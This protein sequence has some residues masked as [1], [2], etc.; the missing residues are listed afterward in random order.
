MTP[1]LP[2][3]LILLL[4]VPAA[5]AGHP[6]TDGAHDADSMSATHGIP[7]GKAFWRADAGHISG[8]IPIIR[9]GQPDGHH[10]GNDS[11]FSLQTKSIRVNWSGDGIRIK[12][13]GVPGHGLDVKTSVQ[14][15]DLSPMAFFTEREESPAADL[16]GK[17]LQF[18]RK[19]GPVPHVEY[20]APEEDADGFSVAWIFEHRPL[21]PGD[22]EVWISSGQQVRI[23]NTTDGHFIVSR[24]G[25]GF[26]AT[27]SLRISRAFLIDS[28]GM[29]VPMD[30]IIEGGSIRWR[31]PA[32]VLENAVYPLCLDPVIG[33]ERGV[34]LVSVTNNDNPQFSPRIVAVDD[35]FLAVWADQLPDGNHRIW[36]TRIDSLGNVL[37]PGGFLVSSDAGDNVNPAIAVGFESIL[38]VW[39]ERSR[40]DDSRIMGMVL[41]R[42]SASPLLSDP[43]EIMDEAGLQQ[44]PAVASAAN[45]FLVACQS[46][47]SV[48]GRSDFDIIA[49][50]VDATGSLPD[51]GPLSITDAPFN[52]LRPAMTSTDITFQLIWEDLRDGRSSQIYGVEI[53]AVE[54]PEDVEPVALTNT[55]SSILMP[56]IARSSAGTVI[57]YQMRGD[58]DKYGIY[59]QPADF[60]EGA[61]TVRNPLPVIQDDQDRTRPALAFVDDGWLV[62]WEHASTETGFLRRNIQA[63]LMDPELAPVTGDIIELTDHERPQSR[64]SVAAIGPVTAT[65]WEDFRSGDNL[66]IY[67]RMGL[68]STGDGIL[69]NTTAEQ[70]ASNV[71]SDQDY[72]AVT[73]AGDVAYIAWSEKSPETGYDIF[74]LRVNRETGEVLDGSPRL[75]AG[76]PGDQTQ[77]SL[78]AGFG[79]L[80]AAWRSVSPEGDTSIQGL[81][82]PLDYSEETEATGAS[83]VQ[84]AG[85][86]RTPKILTGDNQLILLWHS[87]TTAGAQQQVSAQ[88]FSTLLQRINPVPVRLSEAAVRA[89]SPDATVMDGELIF[90]FLQRH[91][92]N[93]MG[94]RAGW[95]PSRYVEGRVPVFFFE[96]EPETDHEAPAVTAHEESV[97]VVW[98]AQSDDETESR[99][100]STR[101]FLRQGPGEYE[102]AGTANLTPQVPVDAVPF[103]IN[104]IHDNAVVFW[105]ED[106]ESADPRL[107]VSRLNHDGRNTMDFGQFLVTPDVEVRRIASDAAGNSSVVAYTRL[108]PPDQGKVLYRFAAVE[109]SPRLVLSPEVVGDFALDDR[110]PLTRSAEIIDYD[111]ANFGSGRLQIVLDNTSPLDRLE[112]Y[113][114][115]ESIVIEENS[116]LYQDQIIGLFSGGNPGQSTMEV[117]LTRRATQE[118]LAALLKAAHYNFQAIEPER[119]LTT[120]SGRITLF[121][122]NGGISS[123]APF[124]IQIEAQSGP[125]EIRS[126]PPDRTVNPGDSVTLTAEVAGAIPLNY[127]WLLNGTRIAG[128]QS[129]ILT[130]NS[131]S[132]RNAGDY[133]LEVWN[134]EG[135]ILSDPVTIDMVT[136]DLCVRWRSEIGRV[137]HVVGKVAASDS[138]WSSVSPAIQATRT[139]SEF[140]LPLTS[141]FRLFEVRDGPPS[142]FTILEPEEPIDQ[143]AAFVQNQEICLSWAAVPGAPY[144]VQS[145]NPE[146]NQWND[147]GDD[148]IFQSFEGLFCLT[149]E[150]RSQY[151]RVL[152][153][154]E[155]STRPI[156]VPIRNFLLDGENFQFSWDGVPSRFYQVQFT[157][158]LGRGWRN[159]ISTVEDTSFDFTFNEPVSAFNEEDAV[160]FRVLQLP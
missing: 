59:A 145:R 17:S 122:G 159:F 126:M 61:L 75:L 78:V 33:P 91:E 112:F 39:E 105:Q 109:N 110:L 69:I 108:I 92:N 142:A 36:G 30:G 49:Q 84:G 53:P 4:A 140:C 86:Y 71:P 74:L 63:L 57:A 158:D 96:P 160:F 67:Y 62:V 66:D 32:E 89:S 90:C 151:F 15:A 73:I 125:P 93:L 79:R 11:S 16:V 64:P 37:D 149:P 132:F 87:V 146:D 24:S 106:P 104:G 152:G 124:T 141:P 81:S 83:L 114:E 139:Q 25:D 50:R 119:A 72:P 43:I 115:S 31:I 55:G 6:A 27:P 8:A 99:F 117:I 128:A 38:V 3:F 143:L 51:P 70:V 120:R 48:D 133:R 111:S 144:R 127:Q 76:A 7:A 9:H 134:T 113:D 12:H 147:L 45:R 18:F 22:L 156:T 60:S 44:M 40:E 28:G 26:G 157:Y 20:F 123:P 154:P 19:S 10:P 29:R 138:Q 54:L 23:E 101:T 100:L 65:I 58:Q 80:F 5:L 150:E 116:L 34:P 148:L 98:S 82:L 97:S 77:T 137:Y 135:R 68:A 94:L 88:Y 107:V 118:G 42:E 1:A 153:P 95:L 13:I 47:S 136:V 131:F 14:P 46:E 21:I 130:I 52:Q 56:S 41:S 35:F 155:A 2:R 102:E 129:R 103:A 85:D 121:D